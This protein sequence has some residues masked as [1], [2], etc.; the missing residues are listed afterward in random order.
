MK[1]Y[2]IVI[3]G[4]KLQMGYKKNVLKELHIKSWK[5]LYKMYKT[6]S[7]SLTENKIIITPYVYTQ[8]GVFPDTEIKTYFDIWDYNSAIIQLLKL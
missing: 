4:Y 7:L 5:T 8:K 3:Q 2:N 6:I 1:L